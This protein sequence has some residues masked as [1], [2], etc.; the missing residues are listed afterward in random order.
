MKPCS[1]YNRNGDIFT[2]EFIDQNTIN[3][4]FDHDS[5]Y[6]RSFEYIDFEN[7]P[8]LSKGM[9][10]EK[11]N[12]QLANYIIEDIEKKNNKPF[13]LIVRYESK[14][15]IAKHYL[16]QVFKNTPNLDYNK[17]TKEYIKNLYINDNVYYEFKYHLSGNY[18]YRKIRDE[19]C[20]LSI[21]HLEGPKSEYMLWRIDKSLSSFN[22]RLKKIYEVIN[23]GATNKETN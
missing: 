1:H 2:F 3:I 13:T 7:G 20:V 14:E 15:N 9:C 18:T 23:N 22:L 4:K 19:I 21:N 16:D 6:R 11:I 8:F 5:K 17:D 12:Y 10:L